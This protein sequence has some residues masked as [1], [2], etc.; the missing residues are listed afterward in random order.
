MII[1]YQ[2]T[3]AKFADDVL[4]DRIEGEILK[5]F[6]LHL[7]HGVSQREVLSWKNSMQYMD[8]VL[9]DPYI[10]DDCGVAIEYRL[11]QSAKRI[12]F[13]VTGLGEND[14]ECARLI[15]LKQ[16]SEASLSIKME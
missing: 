9:N 6:K 4:E 12:D 3:K 16:W 1:V 10:P 5:Y 11:P 2:A 7:N 14:V 13:I 8:R 15:E